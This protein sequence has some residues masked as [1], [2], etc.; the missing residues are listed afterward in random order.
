MRSLK[1]PLRGAMAIVAFTASCVAAQRLAKALVGPVLWFVLTAAADGFAVQPQLATSPGNVVALRADGTVWTWGAAIGVPMPQG[2]PAQVPNLAN[3]ISIATALGTTVVAKDDGTVWQW[4]NFSQ[5]LTDYPAPD[6]I[7]PLSDVRAVVTRGDFTYALKNDG[8]VWAWGLNNLG[9]LGDGTVITAGK[10]RTPQ[11]VSGLTQIVGI[12]AAG[13]FGVA[14]R[15]DGTVWQ[16]G[17][18]HAPNLPAQTTPV[19]VPSLANIVH[20]AAGGMAPLRGHAL[21]LR[22]DGT[23]WAW[24]AND[25]GELGDFTLVDRDTPVQVAGLVNVTRIAAGMKSSYAV[26][27]DGTLWL[28]GSGN[29]ALGFVGDGTFNDSAG[30]IATP[31]SGVSNPRVVAGDGSL[32]VLLLQNGTVLSWGG[33]GYPLGN[34][35]QLIASGPPQQATG[36]TGVTSMAGGEEHTVA[37]RNDGTVWAWGFNDSGQLGDG[38]RIERARPHRIAA[39]SNIGSV[40]AGR[41]HSLAVDVAGNVWSWGW[42][43]R[44]QLGTGDNTPRDTPVVLASLSSIVA[45]AGGYE[46]SLALG[47][48]GRVWAWG[49][50]DVGQ[51]GDGTI[52]DRNAP[53]LVG[54]LTGVTAIAA[55]GFHSLALKTDGTVWAWGSNVHGQLGDGT[56]TSRSTPV[57]VTVV[58]G[59]S[60]I[61]AGLNHSLAVQASGQLWAWGANGDGELGGGIT[62]D[63]LFPIAVHGFSNVVSAA[64]GYT[65]T[66]A[67]R[68]DGS[69]WG[70]GRSDAGQVAENSDVVTLEHVMS[71]SPP[72]TAVGAGAY[73]TM[74]LAADGA[75]WSWGDNHYGQIGYGTRTSYWLPQPVSGPAGVG[76]LKLGASGTLQDDFDGDGRSDILWR[77]SATG[78]NYVYP[79][80]GTTILAGEGYVRTVA[81]TN[82]KIAGIGDF[83]G[84]GKSD[85]LWRNTSTGENYIYL[86]NGTTIAGEGYI[87]TVADQN[88]QVARVGDFD[89]DGKDD[90]LWRNA[91]TGEN[92]VYPMDGLSIKAGEGYLRTVADTNWSIVAVAD[93]DGD[94]KADVLWRNASTGQNYLYPMDGAAIKPSEGFLRTVADLSWKVAGVGDLD[95]DGKADIV[96][97]N[98]STGENY[99]YP[100]NGT[101]IKPTEGFLRTVADLNW[102]IAAVGDYDGDGKSDLFWRNSSTGENYLYPMD[103]TTIK[104]TEGFVRTVPVGS[105]TTVN[106]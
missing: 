99:L 17:G 94:G 5:L 3:V 7:T 82:W 79:M 32:T 16:W 42:N 45:V 40:G 59:V 102:Q 25:A 4:G 38:T 8:T 30:S 96:W 26:T 72:F 51:L 98:S 50:N 46:H 34:G 28:W 57:Q 15:S 100:M 70:W 71:T 69:V 35:V 87:R 14:L 66:V 37:R 24:G 62:N 2:F 85:I 47:A 65:H 13:S 56:T 88:W 39:L 60:K 19:Q 10:E 78:E 20:I 11:Q 54:G 29:G 91:V 31:V 80:N 52:T 81:D 77:N 44:G 22:A 97:R 12:A 93:F 83:D 18:L 6:Q 104:A 89:G 106:R 63:K 1:E 43:A 90:I 48:D 64:A 36:L 27:G 92:Y 23:L 21:A 49:R 33:S 86:M 105:W 9:Q 67:S 55:G 76:V 95:G 74:V 101:T 68:S 58:T 61:A 53:A 84:D 103:G 41:V 73:H 75:L